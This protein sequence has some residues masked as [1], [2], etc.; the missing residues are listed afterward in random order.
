[1]EDDGDDDLWG[2]NDES[3]DEEQV[4]NNVYASQWD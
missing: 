1:M 4:C 2:S 3:G